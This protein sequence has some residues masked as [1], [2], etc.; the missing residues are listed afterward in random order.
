MRVLVTGGAGFV[1]QPVVGRLVA[2]GDSVRVL[3]TLK[4]QVQPLQRLGVQIVAGDLIGRAGLEWLVGGC[5]A[6]VHLAGVA[7]AQLGALPEHASQVNV[8]GTRRLLDAAVQVGVGRFVYMSTCAVYGYAPPPVTEDTPKRPVGPYAQS[9]WAAEELVWRYGA[10]QGLPV[11][12]LRP[13]LIYGPGDAKFS[14]GLFRLLRLPV[15]PLPSH[16]RRLLDLVH[17]ADVAAAVLAAID[18]PSAVGHAYN[19]TDGEQ[20]SVRAIVDACG[21]VVG[22]RPLLVNVPSSLLTSIP[23]VVRRLEQRGWQKKQWVGRVGGLR[24]LD[25]DIHYS[26]AAARKDLHYRPAVPLR[27]GLQETFRW[28]AAQER[29]AVV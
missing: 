7:P 19:I 6:V 29:L 1:G 20:H 21:E 5:D 22:R 12:A 10:E 24:L 16:G 4:D 11:V 8:E 13:T 18:H 23:A 27:Q 15:L 17:V 2:R 9:K 25:L 14:S 28:V 26:I 3:V